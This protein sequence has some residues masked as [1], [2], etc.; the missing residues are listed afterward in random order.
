MSRIVIF[1]A[2]GRAGR[3]AVEEAVGRGHEVTA[4]VRDPDAHRGPGRAGVS[5]VAGDVTDPT[6]VAAV[7]AGHDA[8]VTAAARLDVPAIDF[9]TA[10]TEA[11]VAGLAKAGVSRLVL[12][13]MGPVLEVAPGERLLDAPGFPAAHRGF[14]LGHV[15]QLDVLAAAPDLDWVVLAPPVVFL[16]ETAARTGRYRTG[17]TQLLSPPG[18]GTPFSYADL[19]VAL[20]DAI[21]TPRHHRALVAV[22]P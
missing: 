10:A 4:V 7:A 15:A 12:V 2:G 5:V 16:D 3:R 19:A 21:D 11:L 20:L 14:A 13:G 18:T 8:A 9:Y 1:G 6:S 17:G 22:G